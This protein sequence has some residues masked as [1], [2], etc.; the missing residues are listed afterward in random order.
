MH[1]LFACNL[2]QTVDG[3]FLH[4]ARFGEHGSEF[5]AELPCGHR[6]HLIQGGAHMKAVRKG[7]VDEEQN[8]CVRVHFPE[9]IIQVGEPTF[10]LAVRVKDGKIF[11]RIAGVFA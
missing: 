3:D 6:F 2:V 4:I 8:H 1:K 5:L 10:P 9:R 11:V 7:T